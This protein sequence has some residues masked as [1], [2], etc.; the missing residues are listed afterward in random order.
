MSDRL[1]FPAML[2][3][4][5]DGFTD[6]INGASRS[7]P[8][9]VTAAVRTQYNLGWYAGLNERRAREE[10]RDERPPSTRAVLEKPTAKRAAR[11][12]EQA[13][14]VKQRAPKRKQ[15][16]DDFIAAWRERRDA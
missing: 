8:S 12:A 11:D 6:G 4:W 2:D 16:G 9:S 15:S 13:R 3:A 5:R 7:V 10:R 1:A 14:R